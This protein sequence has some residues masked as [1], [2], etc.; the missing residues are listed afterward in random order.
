MINGKLFEIKGIEGNSKNNIIKD[1]KDAS[2]KRAEI[3]V[4]YY[5]DRNLFS[6]N[7]IR[8]SYHSYLR[9]SRS[10]RINSVYYI[11]DRKLYMLK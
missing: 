7:K 1:I 11:V 2:K 5:E 8:E 10:K 9:N 6:E 3:I 4:L